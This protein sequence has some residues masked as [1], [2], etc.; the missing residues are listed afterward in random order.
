MA[1]TAV[2]GEV[3]AQHRRGQGYVAFAALAWSTAGVLQRA[4]HV[5]AGTQLAG[6]ALFA[7][8]ALLAFVAVLERG[9]LAAAFR[10]AGTAGLGVAVAM[11]VSSASFIVALNHASVA[12]VLFVQAAAP[13]LAALLGRVLLG[14][15]VAPRTWLAMGLALA[16][17]ALMVGG[18]GGGSLLGSAVS[19]LMAFSFA[20]AIVIAR[21]R[22]DVSMAPAT[23]LAQLLILLGA[24]P[25][26]QPATVH[27]RDV[28]LFAL[29]GVGQ[30]A[31][32]LV[33]LAMGA[34]LIPAAEVALISLLEVVLGPLWVWL[35]NGERPEAGTLAGGGVVILAV[36][37]QVLGERGRRRADVALP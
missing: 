12:H 17:L 3:R 34:R 20:V 27:G 7:V 30:M 5:S 16:G 6:R 32:G 10:S 11:A 13:F 2:A 22:R 28:L 24:A 35:A 1:A 14:E 8:L 31:L 9:R 33:F 21:H 26:A 36:L 23:C 25:F 4:L 15:Q 29:L 37:V 19:L 18:P